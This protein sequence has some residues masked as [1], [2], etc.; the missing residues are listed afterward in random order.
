MNDTYVGKVKDKQNANRC[1][2][3]AK[4]A[5]A[6][7]V[8]QV[9]EPQFDEKGHMTRGV[10][11]RHLVLPSWK[12]DSKAIVKYLYET[13]GDT[14]FISLMNQYT[15]L[16]QVKD[17]RP[18]NRKLTTYEYRQVVDYAVD[19]GVVNGFMQEG[20]TAKESFIPTFDT[21]GI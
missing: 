14:I 5:I 4:E 15:P 17:I 19:L 20:K 6:E 2:K 21:T 8:R 9:G 10:I 7:M 1:L 11:V 3:T 18:L 12:E 16:P 13:Y